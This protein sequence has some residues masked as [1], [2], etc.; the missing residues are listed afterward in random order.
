MYDENSEIFGGLISCKKEKKQL[1][2][3]TYRYGKTLMSILFKKHTLKPTAKQKTEN[4]NI[5]RFI[6]NAEISVTVAIH[7]YECLF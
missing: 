3:V 6:W 2:N 5:A 4:G 1:I 7:C